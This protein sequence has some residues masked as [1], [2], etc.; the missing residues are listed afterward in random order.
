LLAVAE[1]LLKQIA[2]LI[3]ETEDLIEQIMDL[4][5]DIGAFARSNQRFAQSNR[6]FA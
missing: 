3:F 2:G 1:D 4:I 6:S 5:I